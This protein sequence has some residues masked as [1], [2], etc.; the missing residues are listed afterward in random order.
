MAGLESEP[1]VEVEVEVE[2][3]IGVELE[4]EEQLL[5]WPSTHS[6]PAF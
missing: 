5:D 2:V 1:E 3:G 6:E 4:F